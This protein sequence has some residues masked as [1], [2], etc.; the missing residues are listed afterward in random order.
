[1]HLCA[2]NTFTGDKK[3]RVHKQYELIKRIIE[4]NP[5]N[6][7]D[8]IDKNFEKI[9]LDIYDSVVTSGD[10]IYPESPKSLG[11]SSGFVS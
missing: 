4:T 8:I 9:D 10:V 7:L 2:I 3:N 11:K 5:N 1:M 6:H